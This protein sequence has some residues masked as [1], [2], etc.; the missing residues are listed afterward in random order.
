MRPHRRQDDDQPMLCAVYKSRKKPDTYLYIR[1][2][3]DFTE[4]PEQLLSLFGQPEFVML[5]P[6]AKRPQLARLSTAQLQQALDTDGYY[7][8][9]PPPTENLL[10]AHRQAQGVE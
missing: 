5:L 1:R 8:Q 2:R 4:V 6:L 7:L 3:D 9:L 10:K